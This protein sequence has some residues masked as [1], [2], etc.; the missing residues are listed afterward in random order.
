MISH[1][2][3]PPMAQISMVM[4]LMGI[5]G[6]RKR[7]VRNNRSTP[8]TALMA[9]PTN[10]PPKAISVVRG[11]EINNTTTNMT[12]T[13]STSNSMPHNFSRRPDYLPLFTQMPRETV[14]LIRIGPK[15]VPHKAAKRCEG[16]FV[17][18][19]LVTKAHI[20]MPFGYLLDSLRSRILGN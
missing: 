11:T 13:M 12:T 4:M 14:Q 9:N 18:P 7:F 16:G 3:T 8:T 1:P 15:W 6:E 20:E 17:A 10:P 2:A 5:G 19:F